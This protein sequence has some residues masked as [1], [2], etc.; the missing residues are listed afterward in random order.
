[1]AT[2]RQTLEAQMRAA[3]EADRALTELRQDGDRAFDSLERYFA[4]FTGKGDRTL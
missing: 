4:G 1:M 3:S 2:T